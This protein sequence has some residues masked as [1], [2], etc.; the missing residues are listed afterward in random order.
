MEYDSEHQPTA[1]A[2]TQMETHTHTKG[3]KIATMDK[4]KTYNFKIPIQLNQLPN[5][6]SHC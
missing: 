3:K 6:Q 5:Y 4:K 2:C 1:P